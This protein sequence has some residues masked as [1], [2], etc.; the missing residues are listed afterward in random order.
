MVV[1]KS[2]KKPKKEKKTGKK[3]QKTVKKSKKSSKTGKFSFRK[4]FWYTVLAVMLF[5]GSYV[6]YCYF[7]LPDI[8]KAVG[9]TRQPMTTVIADNGN[10]VTTYG[11]IYSDVVML[12]D[13]N[14]Y[15][16]DAILS[17]EDRRFYSHFGFDPIA[18]GRAMFVNIFAGRYAQGGSTITQQ[19]AKNLFLTQSKTMKRKVQ[20]LL[21]AF[22][23]EKKF[24]KDQILTLYVNR[25]YLGS[26]TYGIQSASQRYFS[27][28]AS[29]LNIK[30]G[31]VIAGML[32]APT[33]YNPLNSPKLAEDRAKVVLKNMLDNKVLD[34]DLYELAL[35]QPMSSGE[36][37]RVK[38]A[39]HFADWT[40]TQVNEL[41]GEREKD[42]MVYTTLDQN[43]Q[44]KAQDILD[45]T[46]KAN[47]DKNVT[48][49]AIV[50]LDKFGA[51]K[52]L[53]GGANYGQ[54]Q[55]N[56]ATQALRQPGSAFK[57][58]VYLTALNEG[59]KRSD[60]IM[61]VPMKIGKWEPS[62]ISG[63]HYGEVTLN[64]AF[65]RSLNLA[66]VDLAQKLSLDKIARQAYNLGIATQLKKT[67]AL[68]LGA[69]EVKVIDMAAAYATIANGGNLVEP[70]AI[71][72]IYSR[73]G[74]Q[75]YE[76]DA[77]VDRLVVK[78]EPV[79]ELVRMMESVVNSGTGKKAKI[80]GF[81]A[82]KTGTSQGHRDA[83]FVGFTDKHTVAVWLGNDD[84]SPMKGVSGGGLP[85]EIWKKVVESVGR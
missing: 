72:E 36:K 25:V 56:R 50:V 84:N 22:W 18:F 12:Y 81:A 44:E 40:Y 33:R 26:G 42:V 76:K 41:L 35:K 63:K 75:I 57:T 58:F 29:D 52:A 2:V 54:S 9:Q 47:K 53:V 77:Y 62:N 1:K 24:S 65:A 66:T 79:K 51:V 3:A 39:K 19:V 74:Y 27:K 15:A 4:L 7:T 83:W 68:A 64:E 80:N 13:I 70:F 21:L 60:K 10:E 45:E 82:G 43:L 28:P 23:L 85:A 30:E 32:K 69:S 59:W 8:E 31:A 38:D 48:Q 55:F 78:K 6:A 16:I 61:D 20:E 67:P 46:I 11:H 71:K 34:K 14:P 49:G 17:T 5:V 37:R 73:D